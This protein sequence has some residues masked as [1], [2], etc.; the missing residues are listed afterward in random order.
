MIAFLFNAAVVLVC[1]FVIVLLLSLMAWAIFKVLRVLFPGK[2]K[3]QL[4]DKRK[5]DKV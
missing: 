5:S 3:P 4:D 1:L 2:F